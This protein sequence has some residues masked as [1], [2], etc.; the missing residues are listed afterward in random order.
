MER[1]ET[2]RGR[3]AVLDW[4]DVNTDLIIPA[5][6]LKRVERTGYGPLLFADKPWDLQAGTVECLLVAMSLLALLGLR[7]PRQMLPI[8]LFEV[9]WKLLWLARNR[10]APAGHASSMAGPK[11]V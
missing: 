3:V 9:T 7:H 6:Y 11:L 2:H 8:L 4:S 1:F 5:R 10:I